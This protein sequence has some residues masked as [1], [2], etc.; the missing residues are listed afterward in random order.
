MGLD[1]DGHWRAV[2][3]GVGHPVSHHFPSLGGMLV[4]AYAHCTSGPM[5]LPPGSRVGDMLVHLPCHLLTC[6]VVIHLLC[7]PGDIPAHIPYTP[8]AVRE[9]WGGVTLLAA[10]LTTLYRRR[11][12]DY[13]SGRLCVSVGGGGEARTG[14]GEAL[15]LSDI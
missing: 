1:V 7:R 13:P 10:M 4:R 8:I 15:F 5:S 11:W 6:A 12:E 2:L 3:G 14:M 9:V